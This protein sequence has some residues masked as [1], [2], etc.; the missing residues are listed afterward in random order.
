MTVGL[1]IFG[2]GSIGAAVAGS[3]G[4]LITFRGLQGVGA[5]LVLPATLSIITNTFPRKERAKAI[6]IWTAVGALGIG[7]GP[8]LGG[9]LVDTI[10]WSA[11]FWLHI[12][13]VALALVARLLLGRLLSLFAQRAEHGR[14]VKWRFPQTNTNRVKDCVANGGNRGVQRPFPSFLG[15]IRSLR[16]DR[17]DD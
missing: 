13:I 8:A 7:I 5:A 15:S 14:R 10:S 12:P 2:A 17:L 3:A 6:G 1:V 4:E 11:V 16:I 9:Y